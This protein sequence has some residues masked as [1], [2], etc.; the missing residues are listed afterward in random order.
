MENSLIYTG[1]KSQTAGRLLKLKNILKRMRKKIFL[2]YGDG[3][4]DINIKNF[5]F[6]Q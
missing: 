3:L 1:K 4:S 2:T 6:F 5:R